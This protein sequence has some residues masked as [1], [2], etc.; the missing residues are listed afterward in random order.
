MNFSKKLSIVLCSLTTAFVGTSVIFNTHSAAQ[1][2][3]LIVNGTFEN[4]ALVDPNNPNKANPNISGW[5]KSGDPIDTALSLIDNFGNNGG[6]GLLLGGFTNL[7]YLATTVATIPNKK[8]QLTYY[9]A[10][11]DE[12]PFLENQFKVFINGQENT[13]AALTNVSF[14]GYTPYTVTFKATGSSTE[15]KFG[16]KTKYY[17]LYLDDVSV[18]R[19]PEDQQ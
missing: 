13:S 7:S 8:Y 19:L 4:D 5:T 14:Q 18:Q 1:A 6:Q 10:S 9:L 2:Q 15:I 11:T 3:N 16:Y 17:F 12:P